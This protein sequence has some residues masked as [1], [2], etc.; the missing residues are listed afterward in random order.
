MAYEFKVNNGT[1]TYEVRTGDNLTKIAQAANEQGYFTSVDD[2]ASRNNI[3]DKNFISPG[4]VL[5]IHGEAVEVAKSNGNIVVIDRFGLMASSERE[6]YVTWVWNRNNTDGYEVKWK[7]ATG[8]GVGF[9]GSIDT[10]KHQQATYTAPENATHVTVEVRPIAEKLKD[11]DGKEYTPWTVDQWSVVER[12]Y[13]KDNPPT[14]PG[15]PEVSIDGYVLTAELSNLD[16]NG[17][18]IEFVVL[19]DYAKTVSTAKIP[20]QNGH[21]ILR[22]NVTGSDNNVTGKT[23]YTVKCRSVRGELH[24]GW[25]DWSSPVYAPPSTPKNITDLRMIP[26]PYNE[27]NMYIYIEWPEV[28]GADKY[29]IEYAQRK[30]RFDSSNETQK[31]SVEYPFNHSE[32]KIDSAGTWYF[33][34]RAVSNRG[35]SGWT[36][37]KSVKVGEKPGIPTTWSSVS[38][39]NVGKTVTL[40][41]LH[42]S[43]DNSN[44]SASNLRLIVNCE[45]IDIPVSGYS[46][47]D[48]KK[49]YAHQLTLNYPE[50]TKIQW[51]VQTKG[52]IDTFSEWSIIRTIDVYEPPFITVTANRK[53]E[54]NNY[55]EILKAYPLNIAVDSGPSTQRPI[56]YHL[57]IYPTE[58]YETIDPTGAN[59][60][61]SENEVIYS[62]YIEDDYDHFFGLNLSPADVTLVNNITYIVEVSVTMNSGLTATASDTFT[63]G[64]DVDIELYPNAEIV[65]DPAIYAMYISPTCI[66]ANNELLSNKYVLLSVYRREFDGKFTK[67]ASDIDCTNY[68]YVTDPHPSLDFAR[69]RIVATSQTTGDMVYHDIIYPVSE[70]GVI[71][72]WDEEWSDFIKTEVDWLDRPAWSGSLLRLLYNVDTTEDSSPDVATV[73]YIG[74]SH[75][76]SYYGTHLGQTATWNMVIDKNDKETLYALR[77]LQTWMGDVYVREPSG[78]GYW[79]H[80]SVNFSQKHTELTIPVSI[81]ITRVEGG[82]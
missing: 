49:M 15:E 9:I 29:E 72:Q 14:T 51:C 36:D 41:W 28:V 35:T 60:I 16:V 54:A 39:V 6:L 17:T 13:F 18:H 24:S 55:S 30:S 52:V 3:P 38:T 33:R 80:I 22:F 66:N 53:S 40:Y 11:K 71:I 37:I 69:Y 8:A 42:N 65:Y 56:G 68:V 21:A 61:I 23:G 73:Q 58:A 57:R 45:T 2:I 50:C 75:P 79:A 78:V 7:Y 47:E 32:I 31:T 4:Q 76:V 63:V 59:R 10:V 67:I 26:D 25:T 81:S 74:R 70:D 46:T 20:I 77:R 43:E 64:W 62:Q 48:N 1:V 19:K 44:L 34:V 5:I 27:G 12:Y 82:M